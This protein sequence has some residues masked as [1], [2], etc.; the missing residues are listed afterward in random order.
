MYCVYE[1]NIVSLLCPALASHVCDYPV[2]MN[3]FTT[4]ICDVLFFSL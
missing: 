2:L 4:Q 1:V 3:K